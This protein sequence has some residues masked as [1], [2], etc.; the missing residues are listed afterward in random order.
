[1]S[2]RFFSILLISA[3]LDNLP[4]LAQKV[5]R[6]NIQAGYL[7]STS[8]LTRT[9][10]ALIGIPEPEPK[11]G[12]Y[13]GLTYEHQVSTFFTGQLELTYQQ[14]GHIDEGF[15]DEKF[16]RTYRYLGITPM[17]GVMPIKNLRFLVG[18]G[19]NLLLNGFVN[20]VAETRLLEF[21]PMVRS[22]YQFHRISLT[23]GYFKGLT[24]YLKSN[25]HYLTNQNWQMGLLYQLSKR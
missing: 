11:P 9:S 12:F 24:A 21:G 16:N 18:P 8:A 4:V 2:M 1:M 3:L 19:L 20:G 14:K 25:H 22:S 15:P 10:T 7:Y 17:I 23:V 13:G 6:F 5:N